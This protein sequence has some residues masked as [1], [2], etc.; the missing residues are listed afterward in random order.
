MTLKQGEQQARHLA[1]QNVEMSQ[2]QLKTINVKK[3][4]LIK[5][6][7]IVIVVTVD[8]L[9]QFVGFLFLPL[10]VL[11]KYLMLVYYFSYNITLVVIIALFLFLGVSNRLSNINKVFI[12]KVSPAKEPLNPTSPTMVESISS[13]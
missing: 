12:T 13:V 1:T 9:F 5:A 7:A 10:S 3:M 11:N 2:E 4:A 8:M 6:W